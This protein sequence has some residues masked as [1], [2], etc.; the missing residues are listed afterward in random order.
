MDYI[1]FHGSDHIIEKPT[2]NIGNLRNDYGKGFYCTEDINL[3]KEWACKDNK[4][5]FVNKYLLD[6]KGLRILNLLDSKYNILNWM[7]LLL[8]NRFFTL[9][10]EISL[11]AKNYIIDNFSIDISKYDIVIGYRADDS[12]FSFAQAF[13]S[14][15]IPLRSLNKALYLGKLGVQIVLVSEAAFSKI[16]FINFEPIS[17]EEYYP[18]F[19]SRDIKARETYRKEISKDISYK[20]DIFVLDIIREGMKNDDERIQRIISK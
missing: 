13:I 4:N 19:I 6:G 3:A 20:K 11:D 5:G 7:A 14:N 10:D 1:L 12:Y 18:K 9:Q 8:K 16:K 2:F 15:S 17:K